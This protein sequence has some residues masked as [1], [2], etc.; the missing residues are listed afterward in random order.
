MFA[1]GGVALGNVITSANG[2]LQFANTFQVVQGA[3]VAAPIDVG[4]GP[5]QVYIAL[6]GT[7]I[8][9]HVNPVTAVF[10]TQT[11]QTVTASGVA[12]TTSV[13]EDQVNI[14][15]PQS[16]RGAGLV[17]VTLNVDGQTAHPVEILIQ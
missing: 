2:S 4:T 11:P 17:T 7:G 10:A 12:A 15:L 1:S 6:Y 16:L 13:G 9:N 8:R 3:I 14:L 5:T